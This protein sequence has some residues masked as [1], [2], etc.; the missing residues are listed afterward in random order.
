MASDL[1]EYE[2][3]RLENIRRNQKVLE[4]LG[5][6]SRDAELHQDLRKCEPRA[7]KQKAPT[8][9]SAEDAR[10]AVRRSH[11]LAGR[12]ADGADGT[13]AAGGAAGAGDASPAKPWSITGE[14]ERARDDYEAAWAG[15]WSGRQA[16]STPVGTASYEH[17]L[18]RVMTMTDVGLSNRIKAIERACGQHAVAKMKLFATILALEGYVDLAENAA[19]AH[20]RLTAKLGKP[21]EAGEGEE[22]AAV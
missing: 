3:Q 13:D 15:R 2:M 11:R 10:A 1:S 19:A 20:D 8:E 16:S 5:L 4:A 12:P 21:N 22:E 17:T 18:M 9:G 7:K 6:V 14:H